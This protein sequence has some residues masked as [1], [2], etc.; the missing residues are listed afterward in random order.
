MERWLR[1]EL[2][3]RLGGVAR[4]D[5]LFPRA[6]FDGAAR[7]LTG[8]PDARDRTVYWARPDATAD[9]WSGAPLRMRVLSSLRAH[10]HEPSF[11]RARQYLGAIDGDVRAREVA[12]AGEVCT[13]VER[14][15]YD[16]PDDALAWA[17][18]PISA[19]DQHAWLAFVLSDL[20]R[21]AKERSPAQRLE[22]VRAL[23]PVPTGRALFVFCLS[24]LRPGDKLRIAEISRHL[25]VHLFA[26]APSAEWWQDI[27]QA[28]AQRAA[29][30]DA[31][32]PLQIASL[33][34]VLRDQNALLAA[35]GEPSRDL[36]L[37]LETLA[38]DE[39]VPAG[40][41]AAAP[42]LLGRLHHW[43]DRAEDNPR[44]GPL[45]EAP[46]RELCGCPSFQV[47]ACHN[48]LRQCEALRDELLRRFDAES[49]A[50]ASTRAGDDPRCRHVCAARR[51]RLRAR[52]RRG[53]DHPR[54][55]GGFSESARPTLSPTR[56]CRSS[57]SLKSA[58]PRAA[59]SRSSPSR[60]CVRA[61]ASVTTTSPTSGRSSSSRGFA[62]AGT[63]QTAAI[64]ASRSSTRIPCASASSGS[65]SASSCTTQ[66]VSRPFLPLQ[67]VGWP[68]RCRPRSRR[69]SGPRASATSRT[70]APV[71][72][73]SATE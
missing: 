52:Q 26:L 21:D 38:Y 64:T 49:D 59:C 71:S 33:L 58:S 2:A 7:W 10:L 19:P 61:S 65:R 27:R 12:F 1:H 46:W 44:A 45:G 29:L 68:R 39:P 18:K 25:E 54:I 6:V 15:L 11:A 41:L 31:K 20:H 40:P 28:C 22:D 57:P 13:T 24:T 8:H 66:A 56:S 63:P 53:A 55:H 42:T 67:A 34:A 16:R 3:T 17:R 4:V 37:W 69:A 23:R 73:A 14:L 72:R 70:S 36:Q 35:N 32:N 30:R 60:P 62:G 9:P 50:R 47:H 5:F 51:G 43:I 48:P